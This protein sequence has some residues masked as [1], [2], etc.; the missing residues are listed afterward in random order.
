MCGHITVADARFRLTGL[1]LKQG[2]GPYGF[3][4]KLN[5]CGV[6]AHADD[7]HADGDGVRGDAYGDDGGGLLYAFSGLRYEGL[8]C[9]LE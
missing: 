4:A 7:V 9:L 3:T 5:V 1:W 8:C 2:G 6:Y